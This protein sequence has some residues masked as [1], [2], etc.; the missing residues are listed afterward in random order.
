MSKDI[1]SI[2]EKLYANAD[3]GNPTYEQIRATLVETQTSARRECMQIVCAEYAYWK[4]VDSEDKDLMLQS[5]AAMGIC[6]NI[7]SAI[8][9]GK[10]LDEVLEEIAKR[11]K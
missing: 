6:A 4:D 1:K 2:L 9:L 3:G 7:I 5:M 11:G 8:F 10:T